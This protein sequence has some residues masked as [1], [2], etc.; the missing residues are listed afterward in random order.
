MLPAHPATSFAR[1]SP[2][3]ARTV[4]AGLFLV[5]GLFVIISLSPLASGFADKPRQ[6]PGDVDLYLAVA[7][8]VAAGEGYYAALGSELRTRGYPTRS[9]FNWR[10]PLPIWLV[11]ILPGESTGRV[12]IGGLAALAL[13]LAVHA[14][15]REGNLR[16][17][18]LCGLLLIGALLPCWLPRIYMMPVVWAGVLI[19]ISVCAYA[20]KRPWL[21][22]GFG[23]AA[24]FVRELGGPYCVVCLLLSIYERRW[25]E[26]AAWFIGL[27]AYFAFYAWHASIVLALV[28][29]G[30]R[31]HTESWLQLGGAAFVISLTQMNTFLLLLP[32]WVSAVYL[33]LALLG[34][35]GWNTPAGRRAGLTAAG[36]VALF[37]FVGQPF[38]QYWGALLAPLFCLGAAQAPAALADLW[39]RACG[40]TALGP[41]SSTAAVGA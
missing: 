1:L 35:A 33:P 29:A 27:M 18:L 8:R 15:A 34:F 36:F 19:A 17:G 4:L 13:A 38:N 20:I 32:Q 26:A 23:L 12:L 7:Q 28:N 39:S 3:A 10:T 2:G 25:R 30:D 11:G 21:G 14:A 41:V 5:T 40:Q 9:V 37:G 6:G 31:A 16:R 22:V 24:V